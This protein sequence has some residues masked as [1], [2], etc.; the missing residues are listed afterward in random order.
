VLNDPT[1][2]RN[3]LIVAAGIWRDSTNE[4]LPRLE[5]GDPAKQIE[6]FEI[7]LVEMLCRD[8]T[9]QT[10]REIAERTWDLVQERPD[11][12]AVKQIVVERHEQLVKLSH[13]D[14]W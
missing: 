5:P 11:G 7:R 12:D 10:A 8:A 13:S 4:P 2:L 1:T 9:P 6:A 14:R 3:R